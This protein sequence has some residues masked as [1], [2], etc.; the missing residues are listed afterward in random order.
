MSKRLRELEK[1]VRALT[2]EVGQLRGENAELREENLRLKVRVSELEERLGQNS[3]N[4]S[5]PPSS[6]PPWLPPPPPKTSS[7]RK[8]GGQP[9]HKGHQ[10]EL[11]PEAE[12]DEIIPVK[13]TQCRD[14]GAALRG[15]DPTPRRHQVAEIPPIKPRITEYQIHALCCGRCN[16]VTTADLPSGVPPGAFGPHAVAIAS[17]LTGFYRLGR[18]AAVEAMQD[19][20]KLRMS[21]GSVTTCEQIASAVLAEPVAEARAYVK[22]Q[23]VKQGDETSWFEGISRKRVWLWV[24]FTEQVSVFLIR[25][26]R[27]A[28]VAKDMLGQAFGVLVTDRW[29]G[30]TWWPLKWRQLCWAHLKRHFQAFVDTGNKE[31]GRIGQALLVEE[32]LLFEWWH[33]VRDGTLARSTFR[34]YT[35][36]LRRRVKALLR[37]GSVCGHDKT[38]ATCREILKLEAAMWTFVRLAGVSPTNN[39]SERAIRRGV[40]WRK[41]CFGTHSEAGSRFAERMLT[42]TATLRQQGR[43]VVDYVTSSIEASLRGEPPQSLLPMTAIKSA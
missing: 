28:D 6:D 35:V 13:P 11:V 9:G 5:K 18:R 21:L 26:S 32:K 37:R 29:C 34:T 14:C 20:F 19:L 30:Y 17:L 22:E 1:Q 16:A 40:I 8:P 10:R 39:A 25:A 23:D 7:G 38:Q 43:G 15:E 36:A 12:V 4:T 31:A 2:A 42:V 41:L 24:V 3:K 33:R 27:G